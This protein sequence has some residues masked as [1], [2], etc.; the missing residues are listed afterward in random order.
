MRLS[1]PVVSKTCSS[2]I[3]SYSVRGVDITVSGAKRREIGGRTAIYACWWGD[4]RGIRVVPLSCAIVGAQKHLCPGGGRRVLR[5][6]PDSTR[7]RVG[8]KE[9]ERK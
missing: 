9:N 4:G 6:R 8:G 5:I 7:A 2:Q 3:L 1:S